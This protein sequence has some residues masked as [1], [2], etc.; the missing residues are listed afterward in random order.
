MLSQ[1][2][3]NNQISSDNMVLDVL[4]FNDQNSTPV[5][6]ATNVSPVLHFDIDDPEGMM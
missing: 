1:Q 6:G 4:Q 2:R 3:E 5:L